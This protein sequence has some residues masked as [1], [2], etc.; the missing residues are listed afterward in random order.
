MGIPYMCMIPCM[1]TVI[2]YILTA[3][4]FTIWTVLVMYPTIVSMCH[5]IRS[6]VVHTAVHT[7]AHMAA[8]MAAAGI[9]GMADKTIFW[10]LISLQTKI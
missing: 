10:C 9:M 5:M 2:P 8:D 7:A 4:T 6:V 3:C 1:Y